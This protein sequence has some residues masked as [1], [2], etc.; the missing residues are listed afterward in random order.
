MRVSTKQLQ[1]LGISSIINQQANIARLQNQIATGKKIQSPSDDP[2]GAA[3][4]L[5]LRQAIDT[6]TQ[7]QENI[8]IARERLQ[9]EDTS[10]SS[11]VDILQRVR[12][13]TLQANNDINTVETRR[14]IAAEIRQ[15]VDDLVALANTRDANGEYIFAGYS[16]TTRPFLAE[17]DGTFTYN[18]DQGQRFIQTSATRQV[19]DGDNGSVVFRNIPTGNSTFQVRDSALNSGNGII[20]PGSVTD[21]TIID[22]DSYRINLVSQTSATGGAIGIT[23]TGT[24]DALQYELR[25]NG[26]LVYTA[27]EGDSRT[28]SQLAADIQAQS[29][30]T[31]VTAYV[32]GG[33][34]YLANTTPGS[35]GITLSETLT[36]ATEDTDTVTGFFG[37]QLTGLTNPNATINL[38]STADAYVVL[39]SANNIETSGSYVENAAITFNGIETNIKGNP[40]NGDRFTLSPSVAQDV[41]SAV[42]NLATALE[43]RNATP[44]GLAAMHN[45]VN[46]GLV[47]MDRIQENILSV[48][49]QIGARLNAADSQ[50]IINEDYALGMKQNLSAIEDVDLAEAASLLQ[51]QLTGLEA[52]QAAYVRV[53]GLSLFDFL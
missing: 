20:D 18:G 11:S 14:A 25:V 2:A 34:L 53:Q 13:L 5:D 26:A 45:A 39:D 15:R 46:R 4:V 29:G 22:G 43:S 35:A 40:Q 21:P 41:F 19:A 16:G 32:D 33:V 38:D 51:L 31:G 10:L 17:S 23:D 44:S 47:D 50:E 37:S 9:L 1:T 30:T 48:Q 49:A 7:Y 36:G 12:E 6:T 42:L 8:N 3:R 24:N 27:S 52:A 28:Q